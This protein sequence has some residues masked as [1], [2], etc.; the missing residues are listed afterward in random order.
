ME[1]LSEPWLQP[2][3]IKDGERRQK[4][5]IEQHAHEHEQ[6]KEDRHDFPHL[7]KVSHR[8]GDANQEGQED[9]HE[10]KGNGE[11]RQLEKEALSFVP[12]AVDAP[13]Y[14]G[15]V[16]EENVKQCQFLVKPKDE[17]QKSRGRI[18]KPCGLFVVLKKDGNEQD[19]THQGRDVRH[20]GQDGTGEHQHGRKSD[21]HAAHGHARALHVRGSMLSGHISIDSSSVGND[22]C[23]PAAAAC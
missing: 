15:I 14:D 5:I 20:D 10:D 21:H 8:S 7:L 13:F 18:D 22:G 11:E 6:G 12:Y 23:W 3:D 16:S 2:G 9:V 4:N 19:A 17:N 1:Q